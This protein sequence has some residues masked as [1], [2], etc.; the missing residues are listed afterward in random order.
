MQSMVA[1]RTLHR[2]NLAEYEAMIR[3]GI[4][5][6]DDRVELIAGEIVE[7]SPI[8][9]PHK[10]SV[11][12]LQDFFERHLADG[13]AIVMVQQALAIV[14]NSMPQPDLLLLRYRSD[15]Y[16]RR[17]NYPD[18]TLL[19]IE[20]AD[21]SLRYDRTTKLSLYANAGVPEYWIVDVNGEAVEIY[22][23]PADD[24]YASVRIARGDD[25]VAPAAFP[26]CSTTV[27]DIL[28]VEPP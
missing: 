11:T 19:A 26:D 13:Q 7:M 16:R 5:G 25:A 22:R 9:H 8:G 10:G 21:S 27:N 4:L 14:P 6:A 28:G 15:F 3:H 20:V 23:E 18:D 17:P 12:F 1:E 24:A 2:F